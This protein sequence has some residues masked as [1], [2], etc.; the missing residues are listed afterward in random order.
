DGAAPVEES[1]EGDGTVEVAP[2]DS[3]WGSD[4]PPRSTGS[5]EDGDTASAAD[6][7]RALVSLQDHLHEQ[8]R[9][10]RLSDEDA[11]VLLFLIESLD[12]DGYLSDP[13]PELAHALLRLQGDDGNDADSPEATERREACEQLLRT[14]LQ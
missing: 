1:W 14:N 8:A 4:A 3:E 6:L 2:D 12:D 7:A 11:A 9:C 13:L 5:G 10:L